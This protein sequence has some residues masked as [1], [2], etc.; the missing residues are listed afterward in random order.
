MNMIKSFL[1]I[2]SATPIDRSK[3]RLYLRRGT[4][5]QITAA[6]PFHE[7]E[8][9]LA[10]DKPSLYVGSGGVFVEIPIPVNAQIAFINHYNESIKGDLNWPSPWGEPWIK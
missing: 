2:F 6:T 9:L 7:G 3:I 4:V 5:A 1:K 10:T 8:L